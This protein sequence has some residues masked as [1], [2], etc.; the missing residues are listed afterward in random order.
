MEYDPKTRYYSYSD[1]DHDLW[2]FLTHTRYAIYRARE[3]EL[4]RYGISPEQAGVLFIVQAL[5]NRA[6]PSEIARFIVR[7]PHTVSALIE[8]M[9]KKGFIKKVH[10]L[11]KKNLV[12]VSLTEKGQKTYEYSTKR[13][14]IHRI[15]GVLNA[16]ERAQLLKILEKLNNQARKELGLDEDRLPPSE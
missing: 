14:P 2:V 11:D 1:E 15:M 10:D 13:G 9:E 16:E 5:G 4:Q 12:R 8:R 6:T 3:K 7:Q